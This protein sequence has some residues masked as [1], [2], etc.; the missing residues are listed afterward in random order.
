M[1]ETP[2]IGAQGGAGNQ[3][4]A[5]IRISSPTVINQSNAA[6]AGAYQTL[7]S[8]ADVYADEYAIKKQK[9]KAAERRTVLS[10][11]RAEALR[12]Q[13]AIFEEAKKL[14]SDDDIVP[15]VKQKMEERLNQ[16][17]GEYAGDVEIQSMMFEDYQRI[18]YMAEHNAFNFKQERAKSRALT[19]IDDLLFTVE[20][21]FNAATS[22]GEREAMLAMASDAIQG[23]VDADFID[24]RQ[25]A[26]MLRN[27]QSNARAG[28]V[29]G[30]IASGRVGDASAYLNRYSDDFSGI[31][32]ARIS[33]AIK[34]ET[35]RATNE[36]ERRQKKIVAD[37]EKALDYRVNDPGRYATE[38][39][40]ADPANPV[41][42]YAM[43]NGESVISNKEAKAHV[44]ALKS[45]KSGAEFITHMNTVKQQLSASVAG[46]PVKTDQLYEAWL[47]DLSRNGMGGDAGFML[48][49]Y[50]NGLGDEMGHVSALLEYKNNPKESKEALEIRGVDRKDLRKRINEQNADFVDTMIAS[51]Y[52]PT[53]INTVMD[54]MEAMAISY[55]NATGA[56]E[57]EAIEYASNWHGGKIGNVNGTNIFVPMAYPADKVLDEM[58]NLA[59]DVRSDMIDWE[60]A[61]ANFEKRALMDNIT[62]IEDKESPTQKWV[63]AFRVPGKQAVPIPFKRAGILSVSPD[64]VLWSK[65]NRESLG[66]SLPKLLSQGN[67]E[68]VNE[69]QDKVED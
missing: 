66:A 59:R 23:A 25:G 37:R 46:D 47:S 26:K 35:R 32:Q 29:E 60:G 68:Y 51:D 44:K 24:Q 10:Q 67:L 12:Y 13:D 40:G 64:D 18:S 39:M 30:L 36:A 8:I 33:R 34:A 55:I 42:V 43:S 31:Q 38:V 14:P 20:S 16:R 9:L 50:Q 61:P 4:I 62:F 27:L 17:L 19:G 57:E 63:A 58:R 45:V 15:F 11:E 52:N 1:V 56:G 28:V 65:K 41:M 22:E 6:K 3:Q 49:Q 69:L 48:S 21:R 5:E 53:A 2:V 54:N 7:A